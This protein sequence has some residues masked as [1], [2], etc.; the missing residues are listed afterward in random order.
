[1]AKD[2]TVKNTKAEILEYK[3]SLRERLSEAQ[4]QLKDER[5]KNGVD[6]K[7]D[8]RLVHDNEVVQK[9][10]SESVA[11]VTKVL[12]GHFETCRSN[13]DNMISTLQG[14]I[15][16]EQA[17]FDNIKEAIAILRKEFLDLHEIKK[18]ADTLE[19]LILAHRQT[20][21]SF[22][23]EMKERKESFEAEMK[24]QKESW[25]KLEA[26]AEK[27]FEE[28]MKDLEKKQDQ[29]LK[30]Q[31]FK[32]KQIQESWDYNFSIKKR[33]VED[34]LAQMSATQQ[35]ELA[36]IKEAQ[37]KDLATRTAVV[38]TQ[39]TDNQKLRIQVEG[40]E[41]VQVAAVSKAEAILKAI[42][43]RNHKF[44][45]EKLTAT[46]EAHTAV[47]NQQVNDF[48]ARVEF[49]NTQIAEQKQDIKELT[50]MVRDVSNNA[51]ASASKKSFTI[52]TGTDSK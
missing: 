46:H 6:K 35:K 42:L 29:A 25:A 12:R 34:E 41:K 26:K 15:Q 9:A 40:F 50:A 37:E 19:A 1:M 21:E 13:F 30:D 36:N 52:N 3:D 32:N 49:T 27:D 5:K 8:L 38:K 51:V 2:V 17:K 28:F 4:K 16:T 20:K 31:A 33:N 7:E 39:E 18:E 43:E 23:A 44:E 24:E 48:K 10:N 45:V 47:L 14:Q 11:D 22:E